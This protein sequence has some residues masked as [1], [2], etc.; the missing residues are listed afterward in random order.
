MWGHARG[1][2]AIYALGQHARWPWSVTNPEVELNGSGPCSLAERLAAK[3]LG[4][5]NCARIPVCQV[6]GAGIASVH[7]QLARRLPLLF[8]PRLPASFVRILVS[9]PHALW[10]EVGG[11]DIPMRGVFPV[12][13]RLASNPTSW[14]FSSGTEARVPSLPWRQDLFSEGG[15]ARRSGCT[16][17]SSDGRDLAA[18]SIAATCMLLLA[19][20]TQDLRRPRPHCTSTA[21]SDAHQC[22]HPDA[23][24][25]SGVRYGVP[26]M[27]PKRY[28]KAP[29]T[30][31]TCKPSDDRQ[32]DTHGWHS[33]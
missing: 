14:P 5:W 19:P 30:E 10:S 12:S 20:C 3:R 2:I 21:G 16:S 13:T 22:C 4:S 9:P 17:Q 29:N 6:I 24:Y 15:S 23:L 1:S 33:S 32:S 26:T 27:W 31:Y 25:Q 18:S 28:D 8:P 11:C 7:P